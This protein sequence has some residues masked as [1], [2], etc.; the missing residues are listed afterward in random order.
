MHHAHHPHPHHSQHPHQHPHP[1]SHQSQH[2][3]AMSPPP[4]PSANVSYHGYPTTAQAA[5]AGAGGGAGAD[6]AHPH[7][8]HAY[9]HTPPPYLPHTH[10]GERRLPSIRDLDFQFHQGQSQNQNQQTGGNAQSSSNSSS[11]STQQQAP[12]G[13]SNPSAGSPYHNHNQVQQI[14]PS[15]SAGRPSPVVTSGPGMSSISGPGVPAGTMSGSPTVQGDIVIT[16]IRQRSGGHFRLPSG[17]SSSSQQPSQSQNQTSPNIASAYV[18][19]QGYASARRHSRPM[20]SGGPAGLPLTSPVSAT[21]GAG[22]SPLVAV[23]TRDI[24]FSTRH[25]LFC[26]SYFSSL[27]SNLN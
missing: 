27:I 12:A 2:A 14:S 18:Q 9:A 21:T 25:S 7:S 4:P 5:A 16:P 22:R 19:P 13:N 24:T 26:L 23:S 8:H 3:A 20:S 10:P 1:L 15:A 11:S 17:H 6:S